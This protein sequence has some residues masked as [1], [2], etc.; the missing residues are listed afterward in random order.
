MSSMPVRPC[1]DVRARQKKEK[2]K[3]EEEK[4][5]ED[6]DK[7]MPVRLGQ[8]TAEPNE[9]PAEQGASP[10]LPTTVDSAT[11]ALPLTAPSPQPS[12]TH[13]PAH[14]D[15]SCTKQLLHPFQSFNIHTLCPHCTHTR[16][17]RLSRVE[18]GNL[19]RFEGWKWKVKY[20]SP[21]PEEARHV[22][23]GGG[24]LGIDLGMGMGIGIGNVNVG[25]W[26]EA[27]GSWVREWK[28]KGSGILKGVGEGS[29]NNG[30]DGTAAK[31]DRD[32][33]RLKVGFRGGV[34]SM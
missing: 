2:K 14:D 5:L 20:L 18:D 4:E 15:S 16:A 21:V 23:V 28:G 24:G 25:E 32:A 6:K 29:G 27:M 7:D 8:T 1:A 9:D 12:T 3:M 34:P 10:P 13:T 26:G 33:D 19:V 31:G 11:I 17:K 30:N 22:G